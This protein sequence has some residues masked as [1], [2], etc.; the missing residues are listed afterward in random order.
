MNSHRT[1]NILLVILVNFKLTSLPYFWSDT[2]FISS[3]SDTSQKMIEQYIWSKRKKADAFPAQ[4][5]NDGRG[6]SAI[7]QKR[8]PFSAGKLFLTLFFQMWIHS[9]GN[10][11]RPFLCLLV[12][13][14]SVHSQD[15][16]SSD[17]SY[18]SDSV[19]SLSMF[20]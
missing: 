9:L 6:W 7:I 18:L 16:E 12:H 13:V 8:V 17:M 10:G 11:Y 20:F 19:S 2:Y 4:I 5:K 3:V 1:G 15:R 14:P